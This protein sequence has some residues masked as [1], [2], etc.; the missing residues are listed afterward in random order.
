MLFTLL[1]VVILVNSLIFAADDVLS[2]AEQLML[3]HPEQIYDLVVADYAAQGSSLN[4][5]QLLLLKKTCTEYGSGINGLKQNIAY[6]KNA[7]DLLAL[8]EAEYPALVALCSPD[9]LEKQEKHYQVFI[10]TISASAAAPNSP[11]GRWVRDTSAGGS[12]R[13]SV[14]MQ[15]MNVINYLS[16]QYNRAYIKLLTALGKRK[17]C[18]RF[19]LFGY[20]SFYACQQCVDLI[21]GQLKSQGAE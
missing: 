3:D 13:S 18:A 10:G 16:V 1:L 4:E 11:F 9:E 17:E 7:N 21:S 8:A 15:L 2:P 5:T 12:G 14:D 20:N 6:C 19:D